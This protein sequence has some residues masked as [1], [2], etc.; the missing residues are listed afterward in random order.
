MPAGAQV[1]GKPGC[2]FS[3]TASPLTTVLERSERW[4]HA[5]VH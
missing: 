3:D 2:G 4:L 1:P 5:L